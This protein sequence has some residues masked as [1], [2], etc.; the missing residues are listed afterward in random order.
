MVAQAIRC[1][2][3]SRVTKSGFLAAHIV[4]ISQLISILFILH[5]PFI[6]V[7]PLNEYFLQTEKTQMKCCI[8]S[9]SLLSVK[10]NYLQTKEY[11]IFLKITTCQQPDIYNGL[12]QAQKE[13]SITIKRVKLRLVP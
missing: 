1:E 13:D 3:F 12:T 6:F 5:E 4:D 2:C 9:G 7:K 11:N 8:L 10:V